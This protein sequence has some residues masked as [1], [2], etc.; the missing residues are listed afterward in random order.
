MVMCFAM[1]FTFSHKDQARSGQR[2]HE[3]CPPQHIAACTAHKS[4]SSMNTW[5]RFRAVEISLET[6]K[7]EYIDGAASSWGTPPTAHCSLHETIFMFCSFSIGDQVRA[8]SP[9]GRL[10]MAHRS[11]PSSGC[12]I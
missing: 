12:E 1:L 2:H 8:A 3:A 5:A 6:G 11:L 9:W 7:S 4:T 10:L